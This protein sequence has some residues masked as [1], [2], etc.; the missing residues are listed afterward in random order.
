MT[1]LILGLIFFFA[2]HAIPYAPGL[3]ARLVETM[4]MAVYQSLFGAASLAA[5]AVVA[6]GYADAP[7]THLWDAPNFARPLAHTFVPIALIVIAAAYTGSNLNRATAHPVAWGIGLWAAVHVLNNG[8]LPSLVMFGGLVL[9]ALMIAAS[10]RRRGK[11]RL[12]ERRPYWRDLLA[13]L[14]GAV[15]GALIMR[16][17]ETLF[18]VAVV[19]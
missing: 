4:G 17:H 19:P 2:I 6:I 7:R 1:I 16:F 18:G 14:I 9:Y 11:V 3:R 15:A 8:D 13:I 10:E 12:A 5:V